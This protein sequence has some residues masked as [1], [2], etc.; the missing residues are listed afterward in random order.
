ML[1]GDNSKTASAIA[2][3]CGIIQD[4]RLNMILEG[5]EFR[6]RVLNSSGI[7]DQEAFSKTWKEFSVLS[8]CSPEDKYI[9]VKGLQLFK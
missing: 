6:K 9:L 3:H 1:T 4:T 2:R 8:R 7:L 5:S